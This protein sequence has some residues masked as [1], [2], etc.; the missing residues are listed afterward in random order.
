MKSGIISSG[1]AFNT[2]RLGA[3]ANDTA[4]ISIS[5]LSVQKTSSTLSISDYNFN[6][7]VNV[8]PNPSSDFIKI[9]GLSRIENFKIYSSSGKVIERGSISNKSIINI[10]NLSKGLYFLKLNDRNSIKFLKK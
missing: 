4:D 9:T 2:L 10:E 1:L 5:N 7:L 8:Y 3:A 6:N